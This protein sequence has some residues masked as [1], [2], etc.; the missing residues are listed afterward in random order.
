MHTISLPPTLS[1]ALRNLCR[2]EGVTLFMALLAAFKVL[3][4]RYS[5]QEDVLVGSNTAGRRYPGSEKLLGYFLNTVPLRTDLSGDPTFRELLDRVRGVTLEAIS[6]DEVPLDQLVPNL[7]PQRDPQRNP[8][9]QI[10]F[11]LEPPLAPV[12]PEWDLTCIE[13]ETGAT[14]FEL[15]MVLDDRPE[16]LLCRLIYNTALFDA[17]QSRRMAGHWQTLL[18]SGC[19]RC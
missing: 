19:Q 17:E 14:K 10:L 18:E 1:E 8:L 2:Q 6:H 5:G 11:S 3:L 9:F 12:S 16:G 7:Q 13:V 15:C 4:Y